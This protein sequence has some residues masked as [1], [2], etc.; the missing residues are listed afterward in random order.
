MRVPLKA[1]GTQG[2]GLAEAVAWRKKVHHAGQKGKR[3]G[4]SKI[5]ARLR[6]ARG[7]MLA[8][9]PVTPAELKALSD[10]GDGLASYYLGK[11]NAD[12]NDPA[13]VGTAVHYYALALTR[14]RK[15]AIRPLALILQTGTVAIPPAELKPTEAALL[16]QTKTGSL[17]AIHALAGFYRSGVPF[18]SKPDEARK[19]MKLAA[20]KG[21]VQTAFD[22]AFDMMKSGALDPEGQ[23]EVRRYLT[24]AMTSKEPGM[25]ASAAALIARLDRIPLKVSAN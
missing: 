16:A 6:G 5:P 23:A 20:E 3:G 4:S 25:R 9:K 7:R 11:L 18:G 17:P 22:L 1:A 19:L 13:Q 24:T 10:V 15:A 12:L 2:H 8:K 21:D 14:G